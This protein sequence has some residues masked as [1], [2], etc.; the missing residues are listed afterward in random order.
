MAD[1]THNNPDVRRID[2]RIRRPWRRGW[3][4]LVAVSIFAVCGF[5]GAAWI[6]LSPPGTMTAAPV[7]ALVTV[8]GGLRRC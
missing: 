3:G 4:L 2:R 6:S 1:I 5:G 7:V 8:A